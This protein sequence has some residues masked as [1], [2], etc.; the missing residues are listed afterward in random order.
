[1]IDLLRLVKRCLR[2]FLKLFKQSMANRPKGYGLSASI[3]RKRAE[4]YDLDDEQDALAWMEAVIDE[5]EVFINV[6][7]MKKTCDA[8]KDGVYLCKLMVALNPKLVKKINNP[9]TPFR[10]MENIGNFLNACRV[11]GLVST[12]LFQTSDLYDGT[13]IT[14]VINTI[15][16]VGR[17]AQQ[18]NYGGPIL[19][20]RE[21]TR[22]PREFSIEQL[23][24]GQQLIGLQMGSNKG[25]NQSGLNFGKTRSILD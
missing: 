1:L 20:P 22:N 12:D 21:S 3:H 13:D 2:L 9:K 23:Q 19:G 18:N 5:G 7:G 17:K 24:E 11:Y 25:A 15:H 10:C 8:L 14:A 4:K 6:E 16:A